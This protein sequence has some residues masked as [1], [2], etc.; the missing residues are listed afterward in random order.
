MDREEAE[1]LQVIIVYA[2]F[3]SDVAMIIQINWVLWN[4]MGLFGF[5]WGELCHRLY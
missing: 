3:S 2:V 5:A 4:L 1:K